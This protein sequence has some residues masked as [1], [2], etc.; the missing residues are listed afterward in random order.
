M[1]LLS[2]HIVTDKNFATYFNFANVLL[3]QLPL[4]KEN[5]KISL[6]SWTKLFHEFTKLK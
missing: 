1:V 2:K 4:L 6:L 3:L 5:K